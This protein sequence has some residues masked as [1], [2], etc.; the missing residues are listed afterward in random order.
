MVLPTVVV[1]ASVWVVASGGPII[2]VAPSPTD[3]LVVALRLTS[4]A[5]VVVHQGGLVGFWCPSGL[6]T[7]QGLP[8]LPMRCRGEVRG[9]SAPLGGETLGLLHRSGLEEIPELAAN[10]SPF[11]G[12]GLGHRAH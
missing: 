2:I 8:I 3:H 11:C 10:L 4:V 7:N 12:R 1:T 6:G 9:G 5:E